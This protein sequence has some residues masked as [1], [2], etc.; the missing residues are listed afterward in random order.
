MTTMFPVQKN[1]PTAA[2]MFF[3][4]ACFISLTT[5]QRVIF[6]LS[7][8]HAIFSVF[9]SLLLMRTFDELKDEDIDKAVFPERP[10]VT[11]KVL[12]NDVRILCVISLL[13]FS[14]MNLG[15]GSVTDAAF[16]LVVFAVLSWQWW[17]F[18]ARVSSSF[19][20][21]FITHQPIVSLLVTYIYCIILRQNSLDLQI[22]KLLPVAITFWLPFIAW[23]IGRKIRAP[24]QENEYLSY[25]KRWG[26][27][28]AVYILMT[29]WLVT[30]VAIV[31]YAMTAMPFYVLYFGLY[32][33]LTLFCIVTALRF[34]ANPSVRT[35]QLK[36]AAESYL[37]GFYFIPVLQWT[38]VS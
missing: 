22:D 27:R 33:A 12:Y 35:N 8:V 38:Y 10:L 3:G 25:T 1:L 5:G 34:I 17:L 19:T 29:I 26:T 18:A 30:S 32:V 6:D 21:T 9:I 16:V 31:L 23:E 28:R 36:T 11:G 24:E 37:F 14:L 15:Q 2:V 13:L 4:I 20:L 7:T